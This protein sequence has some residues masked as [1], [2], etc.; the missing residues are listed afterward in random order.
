MKEE[1]AEDTMFNMGVDTVHRINFQ[2][3]ISNNAFTTDNVNANI[4]A[5]KLIY[6]EMY[7]FMLRKKMTVAIKEQ[8]DKIKGVEKAYPLYLTY[9][10]NF[11]K[12]YNKHN[13]KYSPPR[14]IY[15]L[16]FA[17]R[18]IIER[19]LDSTGLLSKKEDDFLKPEESW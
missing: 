6:A 7:P 14:E 1:F 4:K 12:S 11:Y 8:E 15:D 19:D 13:I 9:E 10:D 17:W 3:L 16:L 18:L 2:L 5:M